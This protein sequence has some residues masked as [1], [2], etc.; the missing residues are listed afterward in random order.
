[1]G[2]LVGLGFFSGAGETGVSSLPLAPLFL[3]SSSGWMLG[4]T[5]PAAMV[6]PFSSWETNRQFW[7]NRG[8]FL[9]IPV[10]G[11]HVY[12][13]GYYCQYTLILKCCAC[14]FKMFKKYAS[15][16]FLPGTC[17]LSNRSQLSRLHCTHPHMGLNSRK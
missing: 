16:M 13:A 12:S 8:F 17:L 10:G 11:L 3:A 6:T 7:F 2:L 14:D 4:R 9:S 1:M 15:N 5:P